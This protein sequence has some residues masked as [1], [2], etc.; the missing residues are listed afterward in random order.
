M[1]DPNTV[2]GSGGE[3]P[4]ALAERVPDVLVLGGPLG[5]YTFDLFR[6]V[7]TMSG[8]RIRIVHLPLLNREG[9]G[10]E[11]QPSEGL[12]VLNGRTASWIELWRFVARSRPDGVFVYGTQPR[13]AVA[14]AFAALPASVPFWFVSDANAAAPPGRVVSSMARTMGYGLLFARFDAAL[15]LG[16]SNDWAHRS[17][18][19]RRIRH[20]PM[21]AVDFEQLDRRCA[22]AEPIEGSHGAADERIDLLIIARL[23]REK[24]VAKLLAAVAADRELAPRLRFTIAGDG[25]ERAE[26]QSVARRFPALEVRLLGAVPRSDVGQLFARS[27]ALVLPSTYEPWGIVVVES[28]GM[29]V[30][31]IASPEVGAAVSLAGA[32]QACVIADA[33]SP[34]S[35]VEAIRTFMSRESALAVAAHAAQPWVR[36][37][38]AMH[39]VAGRVLELLRERAGRRDR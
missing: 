34:E 33:A 6:R 21:L 32:T 25:P 36:S 17:F 11:S 5:G 13:R 12:D 16:L 38:Y 39:A 8:A 20:L 35:L 9:F 29:G 18:G 2:K 27:R 19:A 23:A 14:V 28:L 1:A 22:E 24:N 10:H 37:R 31:V 30:P 3:P 26:V 4:P 15:G 7:R